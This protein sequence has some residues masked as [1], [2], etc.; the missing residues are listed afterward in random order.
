[1]G[2]RLRWDDAQSTLTLS[3]EPGSRLLPPSQRSIEVELLKM[4]KHVAFDGK[5]IDVRF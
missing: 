5:Q 2:L 1:M 4:K 3:L